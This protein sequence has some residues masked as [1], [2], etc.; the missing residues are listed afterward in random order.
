[1]VDGIL[2]GIVAAIIL[3]IAGASTGARE[4]LQILIQVVYLI[5]LLGGNGG[6]TVGNLALRTRTI[7]GRTGRPCTY[8]RAVIRTLVEV[9]LAIT[10]VGGLLDILWPLWDKQNQTLHDKAAGTVVLRTDF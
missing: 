5:V 6:R 2:V 3:G 10:V 9:V 4:F 7:D 1:V 8:D